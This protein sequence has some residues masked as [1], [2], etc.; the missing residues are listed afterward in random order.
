MSD[1]ETVRR[2]AERITKQLADDGL[3][4]QSGWQIYRMMML[5]LQPHQ[6][7]DDLREAFL[8]G[9]E[10]VWSCMMNMLDPGTEE[11]AA[12]LSR[13]DRLHKEVLGIQSQLQLKYGRTMGSA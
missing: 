5:K 13:M 4:I 9:C 3:L 10:Y 11:T 2:L 1:P 8:A 6:D 7:A 12:D